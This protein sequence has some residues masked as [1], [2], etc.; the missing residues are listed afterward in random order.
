MIH[1]RLSSLQARL[2]SAALQQL[3]L[4][5]RQ[6]APGERTLLRY[7]GLAPLLH[8]HTNIDGLRERL[9]RSSKTRVERAK[10]QHQAA[11]R[12]LASLSPLAVLGRGYALVFAANGTLIKQA[13]TAQA[14]DAVRLLLA[15]GALSATITGRATAIED[16]A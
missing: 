4:A 9:L 2:Q 6:H 11:A 8:A 16:T 10:H 5:R 12:A 7:D 14:G 15:D 3:G 1:E 13:Q